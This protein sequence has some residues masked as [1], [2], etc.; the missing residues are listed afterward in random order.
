MTGMRNEMTHEHLIGK[1]VTVGP[2]P[3]Y[4][5]GLPSSS[6]KVGEAGY[7]DSVS[8]NGNVSLFSE[9]NREGG[10]LGCCHVRHLT[11]VAPVLTAADIEIDAQY[12]VG[13]DPHSADGRPCIRLK[14]GDVGR[15][16][17][18]HGD[19]DI[20]LV[21]EQGNALGFVAPECLTRAPEAPDTPHEDEAGEKYLLLDHSLPSPEQLVRLIATMTQDWT[22]SD[23]RAENSRLAADALTSERE[24]QA[25]LDKVIDERNTARAQVERRSAELRQAR[26]QLGE[27]G[28]VTRKLRA[29]ESEVERVTGELADSYRKGWEASSAYAKEKC[30]EGSVVFEPDHPLR[31]IVDVLIDLPE[32][33][34]PLRDRDGI[35]G[36]TRWWPDSLIDG[37]LGTRV[38]EGLQVLAL[39]AQERAAEA[40]RVADTEHGTYEDADAV[41]AREMWPHL[42]P[43]GRAWVKG[44]ELLAAIR[45]ARVLLEGED[46]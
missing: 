7:I 13:K 44:E 14:E 10:F 16:D 15:A 22:V 36:T 17:R 35:E 33:G 9:P 5:D 39:R 6:P 28:R 19:G 27:V 18:V 26:E 2:N 42:S 3:T 24:H 45:A 30:P 46:Q 4:A 11:V 25:T 1:L 31:P 23:L 8:P 21:D 34:K 29:S 38:A 20:F 40:G 41:L 43:E 32:V 12:V 37:G